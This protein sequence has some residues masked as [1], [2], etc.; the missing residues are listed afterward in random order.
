MLLLLEASFHSQKH[1]SVQEFVKIFQINVS[2]ITY[3][4]TC[5]LG[6]AERKQKVCSINKSNKPMLEK[7]GYLAFQR[8]H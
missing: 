7:D 4:G 5:N 1:P 2:L 8:R 3:L 6:Y